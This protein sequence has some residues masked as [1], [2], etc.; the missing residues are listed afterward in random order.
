MK[1]QLTL[2]GSSNLRYNN[3]APGSDGLSVKV[4]KECSSEIAP[5]WPIS[6]MS[7]LLREMYQMIGDRQMQP[8]YLKKVK[9]QRSCETQ[10]VQFF[11]DMVSNLD[12]ALNRGHRQTDVITMTRFHTGDY[13]TNCSTMGLEDLLTSGSLHGSLRSYRTTW[14]A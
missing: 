1:S 13:S 5:F 6:T 12:R 9:S 14:I 7:R 11:H 10:L 4:L 3:K 8:R 2:K